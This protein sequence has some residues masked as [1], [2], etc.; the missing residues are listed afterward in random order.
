MPSD[1]FSDGLD[2]EV[3]GKIR[4]AKI[5]KANGA[6]VEEFEL[7][8]IKYAIPAYYVIACAGQLKPVQV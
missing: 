8:A 3:S 6:K 1:Y 4:E 5:F 7:K 2:K